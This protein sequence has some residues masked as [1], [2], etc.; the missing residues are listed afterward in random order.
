MHIWEYIN[1]AHTDS[2][3]HKLLVLLVLYR[4]HFTPKAEVTGSNPV[5]CAIYFKGL[6]EDQ[7]LKYF[8][9]QPNGNQ[10]INFKP[11]LSRVVT[12]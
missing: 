6:Y 1:H 4:E 8:L 5:G 9:R 12:R 11:K 10:Q 3:V 7:N 2:I